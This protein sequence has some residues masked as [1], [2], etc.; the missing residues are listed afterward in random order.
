MII[1]SPYD[2]PE[3][4]G[5]IELVGYGPLPGH[6]VGLKGLVRAHEWVYQKGLGT[7]GASSIWRG[8]KII[9]DIGILLELPASV[10]FVGL[11][12]LISA[13]APP[14]GKKPATF[15]IRHPMFALVGVSRISL[16]SYGIEPSAGNSWQLAFGVTEYSPSIVAK[17]GPADP[18]KLPGEPQPKDAI[19]RTIAALQAQIAH[20]GG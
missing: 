12:L 16:K 15:G 17:V 20:S 19:D 18:A 13:V 9:E 3:L 5:E 6:L 10:D 7:S 8:K 14:P 11:G 4:W 1:Q 2:N